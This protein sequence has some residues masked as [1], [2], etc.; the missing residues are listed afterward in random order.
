VVGNVVT[1]I[2]S[3]KGHAVVLD[4]I[5]NGRAY[6]R[7]PWPME[8]GSEYQLKPSDRQCQAEQ[9]LLGLSDGCHEKIMRCL[10]T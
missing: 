8:I 2:V 6:I 4:S 3:V 10:P 9:S 7:D 5:S 1:A